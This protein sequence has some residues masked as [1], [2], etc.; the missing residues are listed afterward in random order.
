MFGEMRDHE[1]VATGIEALLTG[2]LVFSTLHANSAF[3]T[4]ARLLDMGMDIFNFADALLGVL[5]Q[6]LVRTLC[7]DCK[8]PYHPTREE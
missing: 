3:E 4:I 5:A 2:H 7:K 8:E 1:T 6:R